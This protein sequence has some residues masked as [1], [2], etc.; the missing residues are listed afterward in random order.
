MRTI[1]IIILLSL[2]FV[3]ILLIAF[4]VY[5]K[6]YKYEITI[7]RNVDAKKRKEILLDLYSMIMN[8]SYNT[9]TKPFLLYGTLLGY[10]REKG[11][12]CYD[13]DLDFG[14]DIKEFNLFQS[15]LSRVNHPEYRIEHKKF[16]G[17][18]ACKIIHIETGISA[19]IFPFIKK[20]TMVQRNVPKLYSTQYLKECRASYPIEWI[21]PLK[22]VQFA[23]QNTWIPNN[24]I[25]ILKCYYGETFMI[26]DHI[27]D[28]NCNVCEKRKD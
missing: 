4:Y 1:L 14:I 8:V 2:F 5:D 19:D 10:V 26:P 23:G 16:L 11:I 7:R 17:F 9:H 3:T 18:S 6:N 15:A 20:G 21:Y 28:K 27:C 13:F 12:I 25:S 24:S 22:Q